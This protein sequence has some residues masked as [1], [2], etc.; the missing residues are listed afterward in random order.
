MKDWGAVAKLS[1]VVGESN[2]CSDVAEGWAGH[3]GED[4]EGVEG[5]HFD[6]YL[7]VRMKGGFRGNCNECGGL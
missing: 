6:E 2:G 3:E 4:D 1:E 5:L 7:G